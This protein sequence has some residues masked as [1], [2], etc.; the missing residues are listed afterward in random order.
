M[1]NNS[2]DWDGYFHP[3]QDPWGDIGLT[4]LGRDWAATVARN[5]IEERQATDMTGGPY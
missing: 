4:E 5:R 2:N 1:R 3:T